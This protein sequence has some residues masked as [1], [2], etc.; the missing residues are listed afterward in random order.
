MWVAAV[1]SKTNVDQHF[2]NSLKDEII[3]APIKE[4][5]D[6][7]QTARIDMVLELVP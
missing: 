4:K 5:T 6:K 1:D 3:I 2:I 7:S